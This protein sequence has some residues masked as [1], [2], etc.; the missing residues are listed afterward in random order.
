MGSSLSLTLPAQS[1]Q[2]GLSDS[3][4]LVNHKSSPSKLDVRC[5]GYKQSGCPFRLYWVRPKPTGD[6]AFHLRICNRNHSC[7]G[8][9]DRRQI[10][11]A[12]LKNAVSTLSSVVVADPSR[13]GGTVHS[14]KL[15]IKDT[16]KKTGIELLPGQAHTLVRNA[17]GDPTKEVVDQIRKLDALIERLKLED[18]SGTYE[19]VWT[20]VEP[21][22]GLKRL[23]SV[24]IC[25]SWQKDLVYNGRGVLSSDGAHLKSLIGHIMM[26]MVMLDANNQPMLSALAVVPVE[27]G[28]AWNLMYTHALKD[29]PSVFL[30]INDAFKVLCYVFVHL[31]LVTTDVCF[32]LT[33]YLCSCF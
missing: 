24:Y 5:Y 11:A 14:A 16:K 6:V 22:T 3:C 29:F 1:D 9:A 4:K 2:Q 7:D 28:A 26:T 13:T 21:L 25:T 15:L 10:S 30:H 27:N 20:P 33:C 12:R 19:I 8:T 18:P 17:Q 31:L 32:V 23:L